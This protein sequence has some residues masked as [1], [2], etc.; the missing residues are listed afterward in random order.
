M[1]IEPFNQTDQNSYAIHLAT[2]EEIKL[3]HKTLV[4][5]NVKIT[6]DFLYT[7]TP[8]SS[9]QPQVMSLHDIDSGKCFY[10]AGSLF[11][12]MITHKEHDYISHAINL[13]NGSR[14]NF[15]TKERILALH[16]G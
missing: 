13:R 1:K 12:K 14:T 7:L 3:T 5:S 8:K 2:G 9:D 10:Y 6:N 4:K 11:M 15:V 16:I